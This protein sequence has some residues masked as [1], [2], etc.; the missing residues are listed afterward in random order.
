MRRRAQGYRLTAHCDVDQQDSVRHIWQC[1]DQLQ[2]DRV[3]HGINCIEDDALVRVLKARKICLTACPTWRP[4]DAGPRRV[5]RMRI[6]FDLG[7]QVT[8]NS[9]DPGVLSSG[10]LGHMMPFAGA[11]GRFT[12]AELARFS[13]HAFDSAWLP[14][15]D[16][17]AYVREVNDYVQQADAAL[18]ALPWCEDS[19]LVQG[20]R[21][22]LPLPS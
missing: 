13:V 16:R 18:S 15:Q 7:L 17:E 14:P 19:S 9:D 5:D 21:G 4:R 10:S 12:P 11:A 1:I 6:M 3:D 2:V 20:P 22:E 8:M